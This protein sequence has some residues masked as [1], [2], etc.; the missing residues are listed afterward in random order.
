MARGPLT[1][2]RIVD[3]THVWAGPLGTRI[4]GDLGADIVKIEAPLARGPAMAVG[5]GQGVGSFIGDPGDEHWNHQGVYIK[6]NRNKKSLAIDLKTADGRD[7]LLGLVALADVVI[8]NFSARA[9]PALNLGYDVLCD[10]N[11]KIIYVTMP[12]FGTSGPYSDWVAF[13]PSV[14]PMTGLG[15]VVG[16]SKDEPRNTAI[17]LPD[18]MAGVSAASAVVAALRRR[19]E[20]GEGSM[21]ELTLHEAGVSLSGEFIVDAQLNGAAQPIG[22]DHPSHA[23]SGIYPCA[24]ED[25]WI[26][27][28]CRTERD[29]TALDALRRE[30]GCEQEDE[31]LE[32]WTRRR[33]KHALTELLQQAGIAAGAVNVT[34]DFLDD[35]QVNARGFF[36]SLHRQDLPS[37]PLP[38]LPLLLDGDKPDG[39]QPASN[40][41]EYNR[42]VLR[43]W[44]GYDDDKLDALETAGVLVN[45]PPG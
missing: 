37:V 3:L 12:G 44:L 6:L 31:P 41:G 45:R 43:S 5:R 11:P 7:V 35:A 25:Q 28:T 23:L 10:A 40:L 20:T 34:A 27:I 4:L 18:A 14:E 17:A 19:Q 1:G 8:E 21:V 9:M 13:G 32:T 30:E 42:E 2:V 33:D 15:A 16:Y 22:N 29:K 39:W 24:G 38:G 36:T 26:A